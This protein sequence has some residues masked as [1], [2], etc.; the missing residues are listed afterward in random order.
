MPCRTWA[1]SRGGENAWSEDDRT[2]FEETRPW[3]A[4]R[5]VMTAPSLEAI[6]ESIARFPDPNE[7]FVKYCEQLNRTE[8]AIPGVYSLAP[9][10]LSILQISV[11]F[12][13]FA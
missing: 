7:R 8:W 1:H 12:N 10:T 9:A 5:G 4:R 2:A 11:R 13:S 6:Q 3:F